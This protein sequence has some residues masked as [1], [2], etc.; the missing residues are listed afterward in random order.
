MQPTRLIRRVEIDGYATSGAGIQT[1][2]DVGD[3]GLS[4]SAATMRISA[5]FCRKV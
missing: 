3:A 1:G 2:C 4:T 5:D